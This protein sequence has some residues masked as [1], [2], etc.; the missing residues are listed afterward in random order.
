MLP[1]TASDPW[2]DLVGDKD[3]S[4]PVYDF[5]A[6]AQGPENEWLLAESGFP[7]D[8]RQGGWIYLRHDGRLG[9]RA[10]VKGIE[11]RE[12]RVQHTGNP[13][14]LGPGPAI[15][16]DAATW[17]FVDIDLGDLAE[18]QRQGYRYLIT[19][20]AG[21]VVH[22]TA[23]EAVSPDIEVDPPIVPESSG[24]DGSARRTAQ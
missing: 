6:H 22:L 12:K 4:V 20:T 7:W 8:L 2:P 21:K 14:D 15:A 1:K 9:A 10:R 3:V 17:E 18:S 16:V 5:V 13:I 11:F 23:R 24:T 19:T